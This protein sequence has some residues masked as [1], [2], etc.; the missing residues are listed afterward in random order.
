MGTVH[1][2]GLNEA[3]RSHSISER[4]DGDADHKTLDG[5]GIEL[6]ERRVRPSDHAGC[7]GVLPVWL[8]AL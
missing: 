4:I 5:L 8:G 7:H 3:A 6:A 2:G 1:M